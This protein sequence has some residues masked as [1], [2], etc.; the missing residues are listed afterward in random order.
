MEN[1]LI[2][3]AQN[4]LQITSTHV[5]FIPVFLKTSPDQH[6]ESYPVSTA[7]DLEKG[8]NELMENYQVIFVL[9]NDTIMFFNVKSYDKSNYG[10]YAEGSNGTT[11][12][13][14]IDATVDDAGNTANAIYLSASTDD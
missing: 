4:D 3:N 11:F 1:S 8:L 12:D 9:N 6:L 7:F 10:G 14:Y 13:F 2:F 5:V